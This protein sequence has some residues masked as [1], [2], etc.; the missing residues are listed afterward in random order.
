MP[1]MRYKLISAAEFY[2]VRGTKKEVRPLVEKVFNDLIDA[3]TRPL[4]GAEI[5]KTS[6]KQAAKETPR[7]TVSSKSYLGA[8]ENFN[9]LYLDNLWGD[10]LP[11][12]P[13][14][15]ERVKWMLTGTSLPPDK[16][17]GKVTPKQGMATVEKI[18]IN[19]MMAGAKP[20][21]LP[22]IIAAMEAITDESFDARHLLLSAA[23]VGLMIVVSGP[24]A[25]E[26][27]MQSGIG[28]MGHGWRANNTIGRAVRLSTINIGQIW[29]GLNDMALTGRVSAHTHFTFAENMALSPWEPYHVIQGYKPED[30]CVTI[31]STM[32][33]RER[34][35]GSIMTWTAEDILN[36]I[37]NN[38]LSVGRRS[39]IRWSAKG[40]GP[41][42]GSGGGTSRHI[43]ILFPAVAA[44]LKKL[45]YETQNSLQKEIYKRTSVKFE[46]LSL[47]EVKSIQK[48]MEPEY[49][50]V[51]PQERRKVFEEALKPGGMV[52]V[53]IAPE[54]IP[55]FVAGGAPGDAFGFSY[56]KLPPYKPTALITKRIIGA[57]LTKSGV[58]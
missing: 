14:T 6:A 11:L 42:P 38:I 55:I 34:Y 48:A 26:I 18:A 19:A 1:S 58:V 47:E 24:I 9:Q 17:I 50:Y 2:R 27:N 7:I 40:V 37:V 3:L 4:E 5:E 12:I 10:G 16:V 54:D 31:A 20:E 39:F 41:I 52:P 13:P 32:G 25:K 8:I 35:G 49:K 53:Q 46:E 22:V 56:M 36:S 30:S 44:E 21:Y 15:E 28:Y 51:I 57:T 23:G 45:G 43:I 29:P 33:N